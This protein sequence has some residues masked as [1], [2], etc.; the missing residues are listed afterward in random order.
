MLF[1]SYL[2][3]EIYQLEKK[4]ENFL[5]TAAKLILWLKTAASRFYVHDQ[6]ANSKRNMQADYSVLY[7]TVG[8]LLY[9]P[10]LKQD[11]ALH[12]KNI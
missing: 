12:T 2:L 1:T 10:S 7:F 8:F 9:T 5:R 6:S 11:I 4:G 3:K